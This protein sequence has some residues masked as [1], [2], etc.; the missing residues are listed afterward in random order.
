M[1]H[2]VQL[3]AELVKPKLPGLQSV[4]AVEPSADVNSPTL[5][6]VH[7][8]EETAPS[9]L[10]YVPAVHRKQPVNDDSDETVAT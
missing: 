10:E 7:D 1:L 8:D 4:H 9:M 3:V 2:A 5:H 6:S